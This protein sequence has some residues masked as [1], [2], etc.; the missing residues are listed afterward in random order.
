VRARMI[1]FLI[2][3]TKW[4]RDTGKYDVPAFRSAWNEIGV[5]KARGDL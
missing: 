5:L 4:T 2:Y 1:A 3:G